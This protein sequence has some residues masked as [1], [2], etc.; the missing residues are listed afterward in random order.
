MSISSISHPNPLAIMHFMPTMAAIFRNAISAQTH[1]HHAAQLTLDFEGCFELHC[2]DKIQTYKCVLIP[3][4]VSHCVR[5]NNHW[6]L[7]LLLDAQ[8]SVTKRL[9]KF[10]NATNQPM[11]V[12]EAYYQDLLMLGKQSQAQSLVVTELSQ[13][14]LSIFNQWVSDVEIS[15]QDKR[16]EKL[17]SLISAS[18]PPEEVDQIL[19]Q[20]PLS[21]SR[22]SHLFV[23]QAGVTLRRYILW[24]R[25]CRAITLILSGKSITDAAFEASFS[26]LPHLSRTFKSMFGINISEFFKVKDFVHLHVE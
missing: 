1:Q 19:A 2:Q 18:T 10:F 6:Q 16:I 5:S 15:E 14:L 12:P 25:L 8:S 24:Q 20:V 21:K 13:T 4:N 23:E 9:L 17:L 26:D 7:T 3:P 11:E 22:L